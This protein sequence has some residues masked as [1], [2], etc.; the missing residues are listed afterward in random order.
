MRDDRT[1]EM[2]VVARGGPLRSLCPDDIIKPLAIID[3]TERQFRGI[4]V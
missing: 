1:A 4:L 2:L 3:R